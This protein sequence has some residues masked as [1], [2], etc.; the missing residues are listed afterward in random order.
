[1]F[2]KFFSMLL[3][4]CLLSV[5]FTWPWCIL[6]AVEAP[7]GAPQVSVLCHMFVVVDAHS[8]I[9]IFFSLGAYLKDIKYRKPISSLLLFIINFSPCCL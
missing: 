7:G 5:W 6:S 2:E 1:M 4:F 3:L 8:F 9:A